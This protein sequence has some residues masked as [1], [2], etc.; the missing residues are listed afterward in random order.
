LGISL[1]P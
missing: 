1:Y